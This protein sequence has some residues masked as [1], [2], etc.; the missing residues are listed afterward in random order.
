MNDLFIPPIA[1]NSASANRTSANLPSGPPKGAQVAII[2]GGAS[3]VLMAV[4]LLRQP[5]TARITLIE[6][7]GAMGAGV[8]YSTVDPE[9]LLNTRVHNMSGFPDDPHHFH[10]WLQRHQDTTVNDQG[11]VSRAT[12]GSYLA[13]LLAEWDADPRL[14]RIY[15]QVT[16]LAETATGVTLQLADGQTLQADRAVLATGHVI[17]DQA[18]EWPLTDAW[19]PQEPPPPQS[20]IIIIGSGLSMVD[21]VLSILRSGHQGPILSLSRR[22][23]LPRDHAVTKPMKLDSKHLPSVASAATLL[24]WARGLAR[25]A[26]AQGGTWRDAV[27]GIRPHVVTLWRGLPTPE[28]ARFLRHA[29]TWWDV[30]RHR[31]PPGSQAALHQAILDG[32]LTIRKAAFQDAVVRPEG[33]FFAYIRPFGTQDTEAIT[34]ARIVDCRGIRRDPEKNATPLVASLLA[35]KSARI[36]PLRIGLE[37]DAHCRLIRQDGS[38]S[39]R[40][41][42]VGPASRAAFWEITAI[43]DIR[44]QVA[45]LAVEIAVV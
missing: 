37:V 45:R 2:G 4:H 21:Q 30:H 16:N 17:P 6:R 35:Q 29:A 40:I 42:V 18:R 10:A 1:A 7:S 13:A 11:F 26:V 38:V 12:Y 44:E 36:D 27:D 43:P 23:L 32:Q 34:A 9:H 25:A 39:P 19:Q 8:A 5:N 3:G 15:Q 28:R 33:G 31:I 24:A 20:R 14:H 22:G 41:H